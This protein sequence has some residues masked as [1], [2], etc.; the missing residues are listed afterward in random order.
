MKYSAQKPIFIL[1]YLWLRQ[2]MGIGIAPV[3]ASVRVSIRH[4]F[5]WMQLLYY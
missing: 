4:K 2:N 5:S 1:F 3:R